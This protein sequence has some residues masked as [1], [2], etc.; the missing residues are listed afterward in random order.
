MTGAV[1][2]SAP[3]RTRAN[4]AEPRCSAWCVVGSG[5]GHLSVAGERDE[6]SVDIGVRRCRNVCVEV[7][8]PVARELAHV[9]CPRRVERM[10]TPTNVL[11]V[12]IV[13]G[14]AVVLEMNAGIDD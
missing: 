8:S 10:R 2:P 12:R 5:A 7:R 4:A 11:L 6:S 3:T 13:H 1:E 9:D 14:C